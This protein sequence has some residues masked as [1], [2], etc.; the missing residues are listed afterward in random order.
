[1][2][3]LTETPC[4]EVLISGEASLFTVTDYDEVQ[5]QRYDQPLWARRVPPVEDLT[6]EPVGNYPT[7]IIDLKAYEAQMRLLLAWTD[8]QGIR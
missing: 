6:A 7:R 4:I 1:M 2:T 5:R 3:S 8:S